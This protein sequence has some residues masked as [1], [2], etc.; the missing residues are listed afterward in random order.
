M[1]IYSAASVL[2]A[3]L[4]PDD[5]WLLVCSMVMLTLASTAAGQTGAALYFNASSSN[6]T[7]TQDCTLD[8]SNSNFVNNKAGL[9]GTVGAVYMELDGFQI[10]VSNSTCLQNWA[11]DGSYDPLAAKTVGG[12]A[13]SSGENPV[14]G[15]NFGSILYMV[16]TSFD[17]NTGGAVG[18][19]D[20]E[21]LQ[22]IALSATTF[23]NNNG[24]IGA[25]NMAQVSGNPT[26]CAQHAQAAPFAAQLPSYFD[27]LLGGTC[28][29]DIRNSNFTG[30]S[31]ALY[32][33][34]LE[35]PVSV[36]ESVFDGNQAVVEPGAGGAGGAI[37]MIGTFYAYITII[38]CQFIQNNSPFLGGAIFALSFSYSHSIAN[39][40]FDGNQ[41]AVSGGS[42]A[43]VD[44][45]FEVN[46]STFINSVAG[47][48]GG[49]GITCRDCVR[50]SVTNTSLA[51]NTCEEGGGAIKVSGLPAS[52]VILDQINATGNM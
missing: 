35:Q 49:G 41:A 5:T 31:R 12:M 42:L 39:C 3:R 45:S 21:S 14:L 47:S 37:F 17:S 43:L 38:D 6:C 2:A 28:N 9:T 34:Q 46:S 29:I 18:A 11:G 13:V 40:I 15:Q 10:I 36:A 24:P 30:N 23:M 20:L 26:A 8:I 33:D 27:N 22:C 44:G 19:L 51:N 16:N 1:S 50:L 25:V 7:L 32:L 48:E 4:I 52:D